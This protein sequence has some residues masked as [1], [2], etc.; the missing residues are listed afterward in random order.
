MYS[1][2]ILGSSS[3]ATNT[4]FGLEEGKI[5][6]K[7]L[8]LF[9]EYPP[10]ILVWAVPVFPPTSYPS[11]FASEAVPSFDV[12]IFLNI[13]LI[14]LETSLLRILFFSLLIFF[15]ISVGFIL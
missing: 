6:A 9:L 5:E 7:L 15:L 1:L 10:E 13:G 4:Y 8:I 3:I 14:F 11:T 2:L 12:T